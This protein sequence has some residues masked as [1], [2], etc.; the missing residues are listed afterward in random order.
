[1]ENRSAKQPNILA[2]I[3]QLKQLAF[4]LKFD[5]LREWIEDYLESGKKLV[6][7]CTHHFAI[8][9]IAEAFP[10]MTLKLDGRTPMKDRQEIV[11]KFQNDD[12]YKLFLGNIQ[13]AGVGLTLTAADSC[14]FAELAW[15]P[16][17]HTQAEDRIH[18]IGQKNSV[19]IYYMISTGT[20]EEDIM[21][22]IDQKRMNLDKALD[23]K[24]TESENILSLILKKFLSKDRVA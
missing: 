20:I 8:D 6:V 22:V 9:A 14:L 7:F 3:E 18:R 2:Q 13:A 10:E 16:G 12:K 4:K 11:D 24:E 17:D 23:G 1:M 19:N 5:D 21:E 15:T